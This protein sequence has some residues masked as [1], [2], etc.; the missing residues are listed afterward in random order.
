MEDIQ[1]FQIIKYGCLLAVVEQHIYFFLQ[2]VLF[3]FKLGVSMGSG[4]LA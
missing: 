1:A 3:Y 4:F 2:I